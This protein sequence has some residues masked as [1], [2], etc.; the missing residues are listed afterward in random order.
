MLCYISSRV[1]YMHRPCLK[2]SNISEP[3][4]S[5]RFNLSVCFCLF[6]DCLCL[7]PALYV[8]LFVFVF[9]FVFCL[10]FLSFLSFYSIYFHLFIFILFLFFLEIYFILGTL[11]HHNFLSFVYLIFSLRLWV[12][13]ASNT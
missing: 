13:N 4:I 11:G 5:A 8:C 3:I 10:F 12:T 2:V 7:F 6:G 1:F 9:L